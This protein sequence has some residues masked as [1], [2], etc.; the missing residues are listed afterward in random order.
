MAIEHSDFF[1]EQT[2]RGLFYWPNHSWETQLSKQEAK[3]AIGGSFA[4][5]VVKILPN[6]NTT[7]SFNQGILK[8]EV[9]LYLFD[10]FEISCMKTDNFCFYL[11]NSLIQTSQTGGQWY[12][13][14]SPFI[15]TWFNI[16]VIVLSSFINHLT[17]FAFIFCRYVT[18]IYFY[19]LKK[20]NSSCPE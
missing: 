6:G 11:Q 13:D 9:S 3:E 12:S 14:T 2:N 4:A 18:F 5:F 7:I 8:G 10:W 1:E 17:S 15:I 16:I 20:E 19:H